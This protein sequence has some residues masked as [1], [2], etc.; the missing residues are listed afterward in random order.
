MSYD[1]HDAINNP[2]H[3]DES[4]P[5]PDEVDLSCDEYMV[6]AMQDK[7]HRFSLGLATILECLHAAEKEG[8]VPALPADWWLALN[9][10]YDLHYRHP[11]D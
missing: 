3:L 2:A 4:P 7:H 10:R 9:G 8:A 11:S 1:P 6:F 5:P